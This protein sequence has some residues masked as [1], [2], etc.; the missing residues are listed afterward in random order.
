MTLQRTN[1]KKAEDYSDRPQY[2]AQRIENDTIDIKL[3]DWF[4]LS[5][6]KKHIYK[7]F[8]V[9]VEEFN[10]EKAP[11]KISPYFLGVLLGDGY[12]GA[13]PTVTTPDDEIVQTL[14]KEAKK[15]DMVVT[16]H[17]KKDTSCLNCAIV[18]EEYKSRTPNPLAVLLEGYG[19]L[20]KKSGEKFIPHEY[21]TTSKED[22]LEILA[23]LMDT[24]GYLAVKKGKKSE[25][26]AYDYISKSKQ[27]A[28]DIAFIARSLGYC[29]SI[30]VCQ[31]SCQN[32]YT[33]TYYRVYIGGQVD[34]IPCRIRLKQPPISCNEQ[35]LR[36]G[37][38]VRK[39]EKGEFFGFQ[40]SGD[41]RYLLED[42]MVTHNS[43]KSSL[44]EQ[45]AARI[46]YPVMRVNHHKDMYSYDIVGQK[47]IEDG[48]TAFEYGPAA[49]A[50]RQ[51]MVLIMDEWDAT[52]P[53]VALLYQSLLER[54]SDG[55]RLGNLVLTANGGERLESDPMFRIVATSNTTGLGDDKGYYQGTEV[56][57]I[58]F[59][60]R[61][62]LRVKLDYMDKKQETEML[63]RKFSELSD[64]E[65]GG[66]AK[67]AHMIRKRFEAGELNVPYSV[68]D[69]IN[70]V[71]LYLMVG[72]AQKA[73][74]F[75][76]TSILP[77]GDEKIISE[78]V[79]RTFS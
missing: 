10:T 47:K 31:K 68:R 59:V 72:D 33:G 55:S 79:Q 45:V 57:N 69:L 51:P 50:M 66:F 23:G 76:C 30:N 16:I 48:E 44:V 65:A 37:F 53:E 3:R 61:F 19:L 9:P 60:S 11:L 58:A 21:K 40:L 14:K 28:E 78:I 8:R 77:Y 67:V 1:T 35:T 34:T 73:M 13:T 5:N 54:K 75:S 36:T 62:L 15:L 4:E 52:N 22:R 7:L 25:T 6:Y 26:Y 41:G 46:N 56:Q 39:V 20:N 74:Q 42:F 63:K 17:K 18:R 12:L 32:D 70:W 24:D 64:E 27:L 38:S 71:D 29:V 2:V 49:T 43:G